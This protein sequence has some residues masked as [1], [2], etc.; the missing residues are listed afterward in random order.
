MGSTV[1]ARKQSALYFA[2]NF[3]YI[4]LFH[5]YI[6][7]FNGKVSWGKFGSG[8]TPEMPTSNNNKLEL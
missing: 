8:V 3:G 6:H 2:S 7:P 5:Q 1:V 4:W